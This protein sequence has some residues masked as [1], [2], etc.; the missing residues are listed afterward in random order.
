IWVMDGGKY[1]YRT[2][3]SPRHWGEEV[4]G[5]VPKLVGTGNGSPCGIMCYEG[6]L[7]PPA[8]FGSLL[9][10]DAGTRQ[11]HFFPLTPQGA[12]FRTDYRGFLASDD[13]W[14]RRVDSAAAPDGAVFVA[15]WY[16]SG[17]GGHAFRDQTTGRI[18]RVAPKGN[19]P[20]A[21]R[22]DVASPE[23]LLAALKS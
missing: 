14:F 6:S 2:P 16:D 4:P 23:G 7:L 10:S 19:K 5:N 3:G 13:P 8:Y 15:D 22:P 21:A 9:E 17:V 20:A 1:G 11:V 12:A 18:Y